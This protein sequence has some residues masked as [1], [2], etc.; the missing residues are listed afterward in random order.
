MFAPRILTFV[1]SS[2]MS[3][4]AY[5]QFQTHPGSSVGRATG[6]ATA[7]RDDVRAP[8]PS[9]SSSTEQE[10][11]RWQRVD[12]IL[13]VLKI[14]EGSPVADVG[15]GEGFFTV[16]LA[17]VVGPSGR[18]Y[19]VDISREV[20]TKLRERVSSEG[21][22]NVEVIQGEPNDPKLP[23]GSLD[24]ALIVNAYHE[25]PAH[26]QI[27]AHLHKAL[28]PDGR[29]V[30]VE[31]ISD[32]RRELSRDEQIRRHQIAPEYVTREARKG[33]FEIA[34]LE[35]PFTAKP[36]GNELEWLLALRPAPHNVASS[37][38]PVRSP[39]ASTSPAKQ[40]AAPEDK[41]ADWKAPG[42]RIA[43]DDF[44]RLLAA[45]AVIVVDVR[46]AQSYRDGHIPGALLMPLDSLEQRVAELRNVCKPIVT[47]CS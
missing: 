29:L 5:A 9:A 10:R 46:D 20:L 36:D 33:G 35:D 12:D 30:L 15:A 37:A 34:A 42:L 16:R 26:E 3:V 18:V 39:P 14:F 22:H 13:R 11:E 23:V 28:K 40:P 17:R 38:A 43:P 32:A 1:L 4:A 31:P 24:A 21:L 19:A 7:Q 6:T 45:D 25:M 44:K 41:D 27:L 8:Q 2:L 47:Y